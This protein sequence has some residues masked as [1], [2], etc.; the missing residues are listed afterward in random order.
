[1]AGSE[2]NLRLAECEG[3]W[4]GSKP[5]RLS[6]RSCAVRQETNS[7][8]P[9]RS[10]R[11]LSLTLPLGSVITAPTYFVGFPGSSFPTANRGSAL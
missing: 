3:W 6:R 10:H 4:Y 2:K 7:P 8:G 5:P 1:M 9:Y 11:E